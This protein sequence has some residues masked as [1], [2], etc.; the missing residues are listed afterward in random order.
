M[1]YNSDLADQHRRAASYV[2]RILRGAHV[3]DLS[4][5]FPT[6]YKLAV[7]MKTAKAI[8]TVYGRAR[9]TTQ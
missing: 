4:V 5:Q 2:D 6:E 9:G 1:S 8:T 7:N 3:A